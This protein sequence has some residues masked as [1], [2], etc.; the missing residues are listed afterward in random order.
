MICGVEATGPPDLCGLSEAQWCGGFLSADSFGIF[1]NRNEIWC[2][3]RLPQGQSPVTTSSVNDDKWTGFSVVRCVCK[4]TS[5]TKSGSLFSSQLGQLLSGPTDLFVLEPYG[6]HSKI[7]GCCGSASIP[8]SV[9]P[10]QFLWYKNQLQWSLEFQN[11]YS[12]VSTNGGTPQ[13]PVSRPV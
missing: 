2:P 4:T 10:E 12:E 1:Q 11:H 9:L 6:F 3:W 8:H 5:I 7:S 13:I